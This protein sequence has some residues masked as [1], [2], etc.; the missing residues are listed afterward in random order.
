MKP[1]INILL[2]AIYMFICLW[3]IGST[4]DALPFHI[5][6]ILV[7]LFAI[8]GALYLAEF[9]AE[10]INKLIEWVKKEKKIRNG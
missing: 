3:A 8:G 10:Y 9:G 2:S 5:S 4:V 1:F 6:D 7:G